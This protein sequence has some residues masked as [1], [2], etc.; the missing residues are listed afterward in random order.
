VMQAAWRLCQSKS[1]AQ[2]ATACAIPVWL[3]T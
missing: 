1:E 2:A 3:F